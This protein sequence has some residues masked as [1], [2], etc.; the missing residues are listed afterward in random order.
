M[1][2]RL[3]SVLCGI[4]GV[5]VVAAGL[6]LFSLFFRYHGPGGSTPTA[7]PLGP[8]GVYFA[9]FAGCALTAWGGCVIAA[10]RRP[11]LAG[12]VAT[13]TAVGLVMSGAYRL[14]AWLVGDYALLG[15]LP[16]IEAAIFLLL[17]LAFVWLRPPAA[18][19][20]AAS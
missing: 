9:T 14:L 5:V 15:E 13:A 3:F 2:G 4:V 6:A 7:L 8:G 11:E 17:A 12:P 18:A 10:A 1:R 20:S 19:G 16:R